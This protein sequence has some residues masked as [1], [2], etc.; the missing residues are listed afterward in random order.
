MLREFLLPTSNILSHTYRDLSSIIKDIGMEYQD[1]DACPSDHIIYY[2]QD[3]SET[4]CP[5]CHI[6]RYRIDQVTKMV[7]RRVLRHIPIIPCL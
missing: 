3:A 4:E 1:F 7:P 6:S 2:Q 5:Q